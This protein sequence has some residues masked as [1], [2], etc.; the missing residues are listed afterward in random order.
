M[1]NGER[2]EIQCLVCFACSPSYEWRRQL[3]ETVQ[4]K[5]KTSL[6]FD[7]LDASTLAEHLTY[8]EY[9]SFCKILV[10]YR[11]SINHIFVLVIAWP[12]VW[13]HIANLFPLS[14]RTT[15]V[16]WCTAARWIIPFWSV[17][18][19]CLTVFPSGSRSWFS[20]SLQLSRE[21]LSSVN[22]SKWPRLIQLAC[23]LIF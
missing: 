20:V 11:C 22:S 4:K 19:L 8:M 15:T 9:K 3:E 7:H 5:R 10:I 18:L 12:R 17:S 14:S 23:L 1:H 13:V 6:L 16:S 2:I 21:P